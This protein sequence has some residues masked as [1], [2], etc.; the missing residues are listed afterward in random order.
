MLILSSVSYIYLRLVWDGM[1]KS[2]EFDATV[3]AN[4]AVSI[5]AATR[6]RLGIAKGDILRVSIEKAEKIGSERR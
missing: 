6:D 5:P 1:E 4:F 3:N 2:A